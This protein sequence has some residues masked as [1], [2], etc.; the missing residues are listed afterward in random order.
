MI[1]LGSLCWIDES[2]HSSINNKNK[3]IESY[4]RQLDVLAKTLRYQMDIE[5]IIFSNDITKIKKWFDLTGRA[6][7]T[8]V[9]IVA[10][11]AVPAKTLFFGAHYKLEALAAGR[12]LLHSKDDRFI[13]VDSDVLAIR[14]FNPAQLSVIDN[15]D[16][17]IYDISDQVFP[18]YGADKI[19]LDLETVAG[20]SFENPIW[21]GGEFICGSSIGLDRL[22]LEA[23]KLLPSYFEKIKQLHHVGDE[24]FVSAALNKI[25]MQ[26]NGLVIFEQVKLKLISRHWSRFVFPSIDWHMQHSLLHCPGS[27]PLLEILSLL[28]NPSKAPLGILLKV[29]SWLVRMYQGL[30]RL[31][32]KFS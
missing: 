26:P 18:V 13:L 4:F 31:R 9:T 17:I 3:K 24:M 7:P 12:S 19:K 23:H 28:V 8:L 27:K 22:L 2:N 30:K 25:C 11:Y 6:C 21:Y 15:S 14:A 29:Y 32:V 16:L 20:V 5:L 1:K 10:S